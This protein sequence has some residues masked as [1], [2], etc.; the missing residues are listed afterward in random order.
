M[1]YKVGKW[2]IE[3]FCFIVVYS[4]IIQLMVYYKFHLIDELLIQINM[5]KNGIPSVGDIQQLI[6]LWSVEDE[7]NFSLFGLFLW[8][9]TMLI[10]CRT[11]ADLKDLIK[12]L[13]LVA[14]LVIALKFM[15][16]ISKTGLE[17]QMIGSSA[18]V[19]SELL[20]LEYVKYCENNKYGSISDVK[21]IGK[22][23]KKMIPEKR[24]IDFYEAQSI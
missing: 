24:M 7:I 20:F 13:M 21:Q 11:S 15:D 4:L 16:H 17:K 23:F 22:H 12:P 2:V 19:K 1:I 6:S 3:S 8:L 5:N 10:I 14:Y 9:A 18:V